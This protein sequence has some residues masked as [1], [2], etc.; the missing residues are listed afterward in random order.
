MQVLRHRHQKQRDDEEQVQVLR[1]HHHQKQ[2]D[3]E[4][5]VQNLQEQRD[6]EA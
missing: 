4:E 2:R 1:H 5:Q 3:D 6:D